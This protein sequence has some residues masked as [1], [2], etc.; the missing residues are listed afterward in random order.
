MAHD[1]VACPPVC[2]IRTCGSPAHRATRRSGDASHGGHG[3]SVAKLALGAL[4]IVYGDIGTSPLYAFRE[5]FE[6]HDLEVTHDGVI[7]ACSLV[8][9]ALIIVITVKYLTLVMRADNKGEGGI[10]ALTALLGRAVPG[11]ALGVAHHAR[12]LRHRAALR[13]RHDHARHLGAQRGGG[14]GGRHP[15]AARVGHAR[16]RS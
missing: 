6:G 4:G 14:A 15:G 2:R 10:L 12:H 7:G 1:P 16:S 13:R 5:A 9:W 8:I 11:K 3:E